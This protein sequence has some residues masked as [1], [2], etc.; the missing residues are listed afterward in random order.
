MAAIYSAQIEVISS[1]PPSVTPGSDVSD[2]LN[3]RL[4][5]SEGLRS[6]L[7]KEKWVCKKKGEYHIQCVIVSIIYIRLH[8][9]YYNCVFFI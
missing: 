7:L 9:N 2:P 6:C 8:N 3:K 1:D 5:A 4:V